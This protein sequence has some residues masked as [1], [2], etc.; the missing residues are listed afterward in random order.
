MCQAPSTLC[1]T[2]TVA[3]YLC[4]KLVGVVE[5][6][7]THQQ[8]VQYFQAY[9][10]L[11]DSPHMNDYTEDAE[12]RLRLSHRSFPLFYNVIFYHDAEDRQDQYCYNDDDV[13][14]VCL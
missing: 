13:V 3:D 10:L 1:A 12:S 11:S 2:S 6:S 4:Y 8:F 9:D 7:E 14:H 5:L